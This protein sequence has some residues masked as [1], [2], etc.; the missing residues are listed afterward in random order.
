MAEVAESG[1]SASSSPPPPV[2]ELNLSKLDIAKSRVESIECLTIGSPRLD[3]PADSAGQH[4]SARQHPNGSVSA[5]GTGNP[6]SSTNALKLV[7]VSIARTNNMPPGRSATIG[8]GKPNTSTAANTM[9]KP[10]TKSAEKKQNVLDLSRKT[11]KVPEHSMDD[12][13]REVERMT[14]NFPPN[15]EDIRDEMA[16]FNIFTAPGVSSPPSSSRRDHNV[17]VRTYAEFTYV[18]TERDSVIAFCQDY[19]ITAYAGTN[20]KIPMPKLLSP[21]PFANGCMK[22]PDVRVYSMRVDGRAMARGTPGVPSQ[23]CPGTPSGRHHSHGSA[24]MLS[25]PPPPPPQCVMVRSNSFS[26]SDVVTVETLDITGIILPCNFYLLIELL[27]QFGSLTSVSAKTEQYSVTLNCHSK[28]KPGQNI[29]SGGS[30]QLKSFGE[31]S[32]PNSSG[33]SSFFSTS[34]AGM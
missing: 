32:R 29:G 22:R 23:S 15:I 14:Q 18:I 10:K 5:R 26:G 17:D 6:T 11:E 27:R 30:G 21:V 3:K 33:S 13:E 7:G 31:I 2:P 20:S 4:P 9:S 1:V 24:G 16:T 19:I 8:N 25:S 28:P 12:P 34:R